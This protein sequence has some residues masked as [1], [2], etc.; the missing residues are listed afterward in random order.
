MRRGQIWTRSGAEA[1]VL[2]GA[3]AIVSGRPV[4]FGV[5]ITAEPSRARPPLA[6]RFSPT[7]TGLEVETWARL[8]RGVT[9]L[10]VE[11]LVDQIGLLNDRAQ[12]EL[13]DAMRQLYGL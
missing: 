4:A 3:D 9:N 1:Y 2:V 12:S 7:A 6:V 13:D 10:R 8:I 11:D 5:T